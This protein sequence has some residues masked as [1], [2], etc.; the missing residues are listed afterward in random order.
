MKAAICISGHLRHFKNLKENFN[1]LKK[2]LE[3]FYHVDTFISTWDKQNTINSWSHAHGISNASTANQI[4][5]E[6]EIQDFYETNFVKTFDYDFYSSDFS[7]L[8]YT[9]WTDNKYSWD[10]RGI[11][12]NI[13]NSSKMFFLIKEVND[14]K[15]QQEFKQNKKY[16]LVIRTRPDYEYNDVSIFKSLNIKENTIYVA[17]PY[18]CSP[19]DDQFAFGDSASMDKYAS[20]LMKQSSIFHRNIWGDPETVLIHSIKDFHQINLELINRVGCL[21]SDVYGG[22]R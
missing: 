5:D 8:K 18:G 21:G 4:I 6:K 20:C 1:L 19:I 10:N 11:S 13:L 9:D 16:D 2:L 15:K 7:P 22:K 14:L 12:N 17:K 3:E